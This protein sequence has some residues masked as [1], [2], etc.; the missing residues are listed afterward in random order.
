MAPLACYRTKEVR[1]SLQKLGLDAAAFDNKQSSNQ[2]ERVLNVRAF[3]GNRQKATII[4]TSDY[5]EVLSIEFETL[6]EE[7]QARFEH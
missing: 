1:L 6:K 5:P 3:L 7:F 4:G 2:L